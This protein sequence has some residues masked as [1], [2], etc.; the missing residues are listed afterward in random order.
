MRLKYF[1]KSLESHQRTPCWA[2]HD[3]I[4]IPRAE[5][6]SGLQCG[7]LR[8]SARRGDKEML[9]SFCQNLGPDVM[10]A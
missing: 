7:G 1:C 9:G 6:S 8:G 2:G 5:S 3:H 4:H 10:K